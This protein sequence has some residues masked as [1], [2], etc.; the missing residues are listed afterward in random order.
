MLTAPLV[1][2]IIPCFN[3]ELYIDDCLQSIVNQSYNNLEIIVLDDG[4]TDESLTI[5]QQWVNRDARIKIVK[6]DQNLKLIKTLNKGLDLCNGKYIARMDADDIALPFRIGHQ[7]NLLESHPQVGI[8]GTFMEMFDEKGNKSKAILPLSNER[9]KAYILTASPFFHPT[10]LIRKDVLD[11]YNLKY[12]ENY[13]RAE[14]HALW[15]NLLEHCEGM[16]S[17]EILLK[18]RVLDTS[19]TRLADN[20]RVERRNILQKIHQLALSK[21]GLTLSEKEQLLYSCS[22]VKMDIGQV[23]NHSLKDLSCLYNKVLDKAGEKGLS[24]FHMKRYLGLRYI[25]FI[26]YTG[27]YKN[28]REW[29]F[30]FKSKYFYFGLFTFL[31][32]KYDI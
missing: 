8:T 20:N 15:I 11:K 18:Y 17:H 12:E 22:M 4:S 29:F 7:V 31:L 6:N 32:R 2:V 21:I 19:E 10:V 16:N 26:T 14:D 9:I 1:S 30:I 23:S 28:I 25:A 13:Y 24:I 5:I 27:K 3:A